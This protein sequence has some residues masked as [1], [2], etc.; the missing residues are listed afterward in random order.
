MRAAY[1]A[2]GTSKL[3][4]PLHRRTPPRRRAQTRA[5]AR[6]HLPSG[7]RPALAHQVWP[8][9]GMPGLGM[10]G[11][12]GQSQHSLPAGVSSPLPPPTTTTINPAKY[13]H[14]HD[15]PPPPPLPLLAGWV[16][17]SIVP[18]HPTRTS[19][20]APPCVSLPDRWRLGADALSPRLAEASQL[21]VGQDGPLLPTTLTPAREPLGVSNSCATPPAAAAGGGPASQARRY[22]MDSGQVRP[23]AKGGCTCVYRRATR[24]S[25]MADMAWP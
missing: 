5:W 7:L 15:P 20:A 14:P 23:R 10:Q 18:L 1:R 21:E 8:M 12:A 16:A 4:Q 25:C 22:V 9:G 11:R 3:P 19:A 24:R 13:T 17:P 2:S 6:L